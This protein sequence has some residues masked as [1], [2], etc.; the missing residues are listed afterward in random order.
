MTLGGGGFC[1]TV[2]ATKRK[3]RISAMRDWGILLEAG[4]RYAEGVGATCNWRDGTKWLRTGPTKM[5]LN[6]P[7]GGK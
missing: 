1:L 6:R 4:R 5:A 7:A 2:W 3:R